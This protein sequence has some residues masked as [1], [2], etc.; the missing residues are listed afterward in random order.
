MRALQRPSA[1]IRLRT[2][3]V[4][5]IGKLGSTDARCARALDGIV[6]DPDDDWV[7]RITAIAAVCERPKVDDA[8]REQFVQVLS[9]AN[10]GGPD[11][12]GRF[13]ELAVLKAFVRI[14]PPTS[15]MEKI[16]A[17]IKDSKSPV[18]NR[19]YALDA[20]CHF[21]RSA[22]ETLDDLIKITEEP[23]LPRPVLHALT[24]TFATL[25]TREAAISKLR[26]AASQVPVSRHQQRSR[27][28]SLISELEKLDSK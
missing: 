19:C 26:H 24:R 25:T 14:G 27:L 9:E 16:L 10:T 18:D 5:A 3:L 4:Y 15:G 17:I 6:V 28:N 13:T 23:M 21:G 1:D 2:A 12:A 7:V 20:M 8:I 22:A 11:G